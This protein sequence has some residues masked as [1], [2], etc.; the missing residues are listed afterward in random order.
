MKRTHKGFL[1]G[2]VPVYLDMTDS[3][4]PGLEVRHW[5]L[6]PLLYLC[7]AIF[8]ICVFLK[9]MI[10]IEYEPAFPIKVTGEIKQE[11]QL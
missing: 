3:D 10:D 2:I 1:F 4:C 11:G 8:G 5:S 7:E 6:T 9:S